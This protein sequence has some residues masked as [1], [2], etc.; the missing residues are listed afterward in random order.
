MLFWKFDF[1]EVWQIENKAKC[2]LKKMNGSFCSWELIITQLCAQFGFP[3]NW[4]RV[5]VIDRV[6]ALLRQVKNKAPCTLHSS[7]DL[8]SLKGKKVELFSLW[9]QFLFGGNNQHSFSLKEDQ[10]NWKFANMHKYLVENWNTLLKV[11]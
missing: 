3:Q 10:N 8:I 5:W 4:I 1:L 7:I 9:I 11:C 6:D 2:Q